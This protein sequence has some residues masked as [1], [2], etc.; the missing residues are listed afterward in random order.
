MLLIL[1]PA[2]GRTYAT[3]AQM[4]KDWDDGRDFRVEGGPYCSVRDLEQL[5]SDGHSASLQLKPGHYV[6]L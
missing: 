3:K 1:K 6:S 4:M 2:Y 5:K